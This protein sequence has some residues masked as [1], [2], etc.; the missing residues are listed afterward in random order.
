MNKYDN[1]YMDIARRCAEQS[2]ALR[3]KVGCVIVKNENILSF[4]WNGTPAGFDNACEEPT[5]KGQTVG[6][7]YIMS[8]ELR[9]K[10]EVSHAEM[11]ALAKLAGSTGNAEGATL[12]C[13]AGPCIECAKLI[14]RSGIIEVVYEDDYRTEAG[15]ELL[16][17]RSILTRKYRG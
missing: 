9:T 2:H 10:A 11:N 16:Q 7:Q 6:S 4:G 1:L 8:L 3:R 5:L 13:T 14:Q 17:R 15:I 12:Y